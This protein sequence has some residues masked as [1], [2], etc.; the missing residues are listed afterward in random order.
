MTKTQGLYFAETTVTFFPSETSSNGP[1]ARLFLYDS[2]V[3]STIYGWP[4]NELLPVPKLCAAH[5]SPWC[6]FLPKSA[7]LSL[8]LLSLRLNAKN[9]RDARLDKLMDGFFFVSKV[10]SWLTRL[11]RSTTTQAVAMPPH[12]FTGSP[13]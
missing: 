6:F 3:R 2:S 5:S 13:T 9:T 10:C 12:S 4:L 7:K 11:S 8:V 1:L